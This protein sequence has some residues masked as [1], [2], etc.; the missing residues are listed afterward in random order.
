[1]NINRNDLKALASTYQ[2]I[3]ESSNAQQP[4]P[5]Y[6]AGADDE[7]MMPVSTVHIK[8]TKIKDLLDDLQ[9]EFLKLNSDEVDAIFDPIYHQIRAVIEPIAPTESY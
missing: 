6:N 9:T 4:N 1:M 5:A 2:T 8:L 7:D 3:Y